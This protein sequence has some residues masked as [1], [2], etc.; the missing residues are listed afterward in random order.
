M[1]ASEHLAEIIRTN[2]NLVYLNLSR[3]MLDSGA[4][5]LLGPAIGENSSLRTLDLSWNNITRR[6]AIAVA[7]GVKVKLILNTLTL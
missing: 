2:T 6:G 3:N 1:K 4:G 7:K 5:V